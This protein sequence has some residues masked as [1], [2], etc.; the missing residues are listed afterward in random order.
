MATNHLGINAKYCS[1][2]TFLYN[3]GPPSNFWYG[4]KL[5]PRQS[6]VQAQELLC[7]SNFYFHFWDSID[8]VSKKQGN[9]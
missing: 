5:Q 8:Q 2:S 9:S 7:H 3:Y 6:D 4:E 1:F